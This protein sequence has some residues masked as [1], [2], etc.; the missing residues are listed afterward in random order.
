MPTPS[1]ES[2]NDLLLSISHLAALIGWPVLLGIAWKTARWLGV[3]ETK[4]DQAFA[5]VTGNDLSH[6]H[7]ELVKANA[8][9]DTLAQ[10]IRGLRQDISIAIATRKQ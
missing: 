9:Q 10:E 8:H 2:S 6:I 3:M 4:F 7:E 5:K 1:P